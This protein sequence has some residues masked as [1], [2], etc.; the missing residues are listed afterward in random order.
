MRALVT[1]E[2]VHRMQHSEMPREADG[3]WSA[4][5]ILVESCETNLTGYVVSFFRHNFRISDRLHCE[6]HPSPL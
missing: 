5:T 1:G 2:L 3:M 6:S 4:S